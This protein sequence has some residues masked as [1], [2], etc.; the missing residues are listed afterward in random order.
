MIR[1][2]DQAGTIFSSTLF[3]QNFPLAS[4]K[5]VIY[6]A[7]SANLVIAVAK[8]AA[9]IITGSSAMLSEGIHSVV[10]TLNEIL[11]L[12]G[13]NRS[14]KPADAQRPFGYGKEL[15]FW[16]FIVSLLIFAIGGG[17]SFYEGIAHLQDPVD[18]TDPLWNYMVLGFAFLFDGTSFIIALRQFNK[19]GGDQ[20]FWKKFIHS[21]DPTNFIVLFEDA[22]AVIGLLIAFA[23][24]VLGQVLDMPEL[25]GIASLIIGLLL[26]GVSV[27]LARESYSL[28]MGETASGPVL[29][30]VVSMVS[31]NAA[32]RHV[33]HPMSM[34]LGPKETILV[35]YVDFE[36]NIQLKDG[37][38]IIE[39]LKTQ[40]RS[41]YPYFKR[42]LIEPENNYADSV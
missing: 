8:F 24:L 37:T 39:T 16:S 42:I 17:I 14:S 3:I 15:Y 10:D 9:A 26:T 6:S 36:D 2:L 28:L 12:L 33:Y 19:T 21:K 23:G 27:A 29:Q 1:L 32:V 4:S 18:I 35:L 34:F 31:R 7:L 20:S 38:E 5:F 25:D 22:A 41:K 30:D 13:I 40:I 11:L